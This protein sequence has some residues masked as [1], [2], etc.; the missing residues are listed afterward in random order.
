MLQFS[1]I[2]DTTRNDDISR[3][4]NHDIYDRSLSWKHT[5]CTSK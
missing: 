3:K 4:V 5:S 2:V 1:V